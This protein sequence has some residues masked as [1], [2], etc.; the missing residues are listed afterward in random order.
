MAG[1]FAQNQY[2][3]NV[4]ANNATTQG[5]FSIAGAGLQGAMGSGG[6][7]GA[8]KTVPPTFGGPQ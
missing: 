8:P 1:N 7:F 4:A 6:L 5:L 3:Q 2:G